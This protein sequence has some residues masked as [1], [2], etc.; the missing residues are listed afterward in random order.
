MNP[1]PLHDPEAVILIENLMHSY[2]TH[3]ALGG[4]SFSVLR[5]SIHGFVGPNGAGKT[6]TLKILATLLPPQRG[7][8]EVFGFNV[9]RHRT[10]VRRKI[11]FMPDHFPCTGR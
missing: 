11:G 10:E 1:P 8:V 3:V 5:K 4:V 9:Q 2:K 6:T 7:R